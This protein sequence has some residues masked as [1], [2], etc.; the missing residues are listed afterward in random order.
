MQKAFILR[1]KMKVVTFILTI[2][3]SVF[4]GTIKKHSTHPKLNPATG[5]DASTVVSKAVFAHYMV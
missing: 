2:L 3:T 1:R 5:K 4:A